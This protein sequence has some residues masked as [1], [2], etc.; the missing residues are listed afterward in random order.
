MTGRAVACVAI[1]RP[2]AQRISGPV[3]VDAEVSGTPSLRFRT[4]AAIAAPARHGSNNTANAV[5]SRGPP[6]FKSPI[7]RTSQ[8]LSHDLQGQGLSH[9]AAGGGHSG[10]SGAHP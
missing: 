6:G 2:N 10:C 4:I 7:L 9:K 5:G 3:L 8:A 1:A